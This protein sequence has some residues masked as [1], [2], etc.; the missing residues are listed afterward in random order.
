[1]SRI[2]QRKESWKGIVDERL[3]KIEVVLENQVKTVEKLQPS[4]LD[5]Q[6]GQLYNN[7]DFLKR[8]IDC[9]ENYSR[10]ANLVFRGI[11][12]DVKESREQTDLK[13]IEVVQ[14]YLNFEPTTVARA[15]RLGKQ[16]RPIDPGRIGRKELAKKRTKRGTREGKGQDQ[17]S[18]SEAE[19]WLEEKDKGKFL[20]RLD[21]VFMW[22][23]VPAI[24]EKKGWAKGGHI[25]GIK[26]DLPGKW[27][28]R[29][30][31]YGAIIEYKASDDFGTI[32][33]VYCNEGIEEMA[34][35]LG[36]IIE[37]LIEKGGLIV[38]AG[39]FNARTGTVGVQMRDEHECR[40]SQDGTLNEAGRHLLDFCTHHGLKILNGITN[41]DWEEK[42]TSINARGSAVV[43]YIIVNDHEMIDRMEI[44]ENR[45]RP[46]TNPREEMGLTPTQTTTNYHSWFDK[47]CREEKRETRKALRKFRKSRSDED[48]R[49][50]VNKKTRLRK[51]YQQKKKERE[52]QMW[53]RI[54]ECTTGDQFWT[55]PG[56]DGILNEFWRSLSLQSMLLLLD[57]LSDSW[58]DT[59]HDGLITLIHK[60]GDVGL[61][62]NYRGITLLN[63]LYKIVTSMMARRISQWLFL[64]DKLTENQAGYRRKYS[65]R[66]NIFVLNA[67]IENRKKRKGGKLC[68]VF[69]SQGGVRQG[70]SENSI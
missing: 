44:Q 8:K 9:L 13:A 52:E 70:G 11:K 1:M 28:M 69:G 16:G 59:R 29:K 27:W 55:A 43:D 61:A 17:G 2:E 64:E 30:W 14:K 23:E 5:G 18:E 41:G 62:K 15:H 6:I 36:P 39:D 50:Y 65:T 37:E 24:K 34:K 40:K 58:P 3:E 12:E 51:L 22:F 57:V 54:N 33:A 4:K 46:L 68:F 20:K 45:I 53:I 21:S 56:K 35:E 10:H 60:A 32:I 7:L 31:K 63:T 42:V 47:D 38:L 19:T 67:L 25:I 66:D 49:D 26:K 48:R